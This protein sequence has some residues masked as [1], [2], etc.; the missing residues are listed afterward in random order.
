MARAKASSYSTKSCQA[1]GH[2]VARLRRN[3]QAAQ[4]PKLYIGLLLIPVRKPAAPELA[5]FS[6]F[7]SVR[8]SS[9]RS[10]HS[11]ERYLDRSDDHSPVSLLLETLHG[12][13]LDLPFRCSLRQI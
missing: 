11:F 2:K 12:S 5:M 13:F 3:G 9:S 8:L 4:S 7:N 1:F 10:V 6:S